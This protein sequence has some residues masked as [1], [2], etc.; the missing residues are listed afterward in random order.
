MTEMIVALDS[1]R[2]VG[3]IPRLSV[4]AGVRFF[5]LTK[6]LDDAARPARRRRVRRARLVLGSGWSRLH[7]RAGRH[8]RRAVRPRA[9]PR[10][11]GRPRHGR[12]LAAAIL[13][14]LQLGV[15]RCRWTLT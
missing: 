7:P 14:A 8:R 2:A 3:L 10:D 15:S 12:R 9:V 1:N 13:E 6:R 4:E 5:K 11:R